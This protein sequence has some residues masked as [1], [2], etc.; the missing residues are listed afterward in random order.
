MGISVTHLHPAHG[1]TTEFFQ[2]ASARKPQVETL[3]REP[4]TA[5]KSHGDRRVKEMFPAMMWNYKYTNPAVA[6]WT[7]NNSADATETMWGVIEPYGRTCG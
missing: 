7:L 3:R 4:R 2:N 1:R 6:A 5:H